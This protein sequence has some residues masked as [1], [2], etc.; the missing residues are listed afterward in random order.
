MSEVEVLEQKQRRILEQ[1]DDLKKTLLA[2]RGDLNLCNKPQQL[3]N[4]KPASAQKASNV[5]KLPIDVSP[6]YCSVMR[7]NKC[8]ITICF[9]HHISKMLLSMPIHNV[10]HTAYLH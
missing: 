9:S 10:Y 4:Q 6:L 2:M 1:L 7:L 3:T 5:K 8:S